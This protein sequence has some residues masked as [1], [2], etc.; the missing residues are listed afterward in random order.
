[1]HPNAWWQRQ[2][3]TMTEAETQTATE[4]EFFF[5]IKRHW[6]AWRQTVT[7]AERRTEWQKFKKLIRGIKMREERRRQA[8]RQEPERGSEVLTWQQ[9]GWGLQACWSSHWGVHHRPADL[10]LSWVRPALKPH[11][12]CVMPVQSHHSL[13]TTKHMTQLLLQ[14]NLLTL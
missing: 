3:Q 5:L 2:R 13:L 11:Q 12:Q 10:G 4:V 1:M 9:L 14:Y 7:E 8:D 6:N